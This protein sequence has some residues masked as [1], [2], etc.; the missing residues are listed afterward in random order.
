MQYTAEATPQQRA[1][2]YCHVEPIAAHNRP[3][4]GMTLQ[5]QILVKERRGAVHRTL[6][7]YHAL[8][9]ILSI[10]QHKMN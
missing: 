4:V 6:V 7:V 10:P 5:C 8:R 3:I 2:T 1:V 9:F